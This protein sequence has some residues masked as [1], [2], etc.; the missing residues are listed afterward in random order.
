MSPRALPAWQATFVLSVIQL[1]SLSK[2]PLDLFQVALATKLW[3]A[4]TDVVSPEVQEE[5]G[6]TPESADQLTADFVL[7]YLIE[8]DLAE[9]CQVELCTD[10]DT[11]T[12]DVHISIQPTRFGRRIARGFRWHHRSLEID[13]WSVRHPILRAL[14]VGGGGYLGGL[15][16]GM[17]L[18]QHWLALVIVGTVVFGITI[19]AVTAD[20][21]LDRWACRWE[22]NHG[23]IFPAARVLQPTTED[24]DAE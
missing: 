16:L 8:T 21:L 23:W 1:M 3:K 10:Q 19:V 17:G 22:R 6:Y 24:E 13:R 7:D 4:K 2:Q 20:L 18:R 15:A 9:I 11:T 12:M 14:L 5:V